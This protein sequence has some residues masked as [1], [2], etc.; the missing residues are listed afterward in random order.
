M[1]GGGSPEGSALPQ[2]LWALNGSWSGG[3]GGVSSLFVYYLAT[4]MLLWSNI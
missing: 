3:G 4:D 1:R 2:G